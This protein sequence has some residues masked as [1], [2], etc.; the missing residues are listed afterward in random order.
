MVCD[1]TFWIPHNKPLPHRQGIIVTERSPWAGF[2]VFSR[3]LHANDLLT[4]TD[5]WLLFDV[6]TNW[7]WV[8]DVTLYIHTPWECA[9]KRVRGRG[10]P[11]EANIKPQLLRQLEARHETF[12]KWGPCGEVI[13]LDCSRSKNEVLEKA[14]LELQGV[15]QKDRA[16]SHNPGSEFGPH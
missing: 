12:V 1:N 14:L 16:D 7:G 2:H 13:R 8:P 11:S 4:T 3:N 10:R 5:L 15:W 9:L 6:A